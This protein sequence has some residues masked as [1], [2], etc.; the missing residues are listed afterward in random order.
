MA[1]VKYYLS[2]Y[3]KNDDE[4]GEIQ[5]RFSGNR[6]FVKRAA[7]GI[8]ITAGSWDAERGM[9]KARKSNKYGDN[10]DEIR[11][12]LLLLTSYLIRCY[13][14]N[15]E[16]DLKENSLA[17]WM[18][19]IEWSSEKEES[20]IG[21]KEVVVNRWS[22]TSKTQLA[23]EAAAKK[24][25]MAKLE[26]QYFVDAFAFFMEEQFKNGVIVA[27]RKKSYNTC[28]GIWDRMEKYDGRHVK[29]KEMTVEHL[30]NFK[31][32]I[33]NE[34]DLW[35]VEERKE[36]EKVVKKMVP[37]KRYAEIYQGYDYVL[38]RG[39]EKR[40]L[41]Y[42]ANEFKYVRA[43]WLWIMNLQNCKVDDIFKN[44][45]RDQPVYGTPFFFSKEDRNTLFEADFSK[46]PELG[47]QRDI[48]VFQSL[49]GCR[50]GDLKRLKKSNIIDGDCLQYVAGKTRNKSGKLVTVPLHPIAK[51][52]VERYKDLEG[53]RL[54]PFISDQHYNEAIKEMFKCVPEIDH[55][56][57][58]L[59]PVTRLE[60]QVKLSEVASSHM[61]RRNF[62]G[63]L[64]EAGFRES[65]IGSM[66]G[67]SEGSRAIARY[68]KVSDET[69]QRMIKE[70]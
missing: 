2:R 57:T 48:F 68:R 1:T 11:D 6:N 52:I 33:L 29:I 50:I 21:G 30:Y 32:F 38:R 49:V 34:C 42:V 54:L 37:K 16:G 18:S 53:D 41:N 59:D 31:N 35:E 60:K 4:R 26:N 8:F 45:K 56:I 39:V 64:Y 58:I 10:N 14:Q 5:L 47:I 61:G 17:E 12:R 22:L 19:D 70:L 15:S 62:C 23:T 28:L 46:R 44:Y 67:H 40:S 27:E 63:N 51:T 13:E 69:K 66:S 9:P 3:I 43:F 7:T 20:F 24:R 65:D 36:G 25:E 55:V